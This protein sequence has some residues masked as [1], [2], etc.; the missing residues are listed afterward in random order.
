MTKNSSLSNEPKETDENFKEFRQIM[1]ELSPASLFL[2]WKT[3]WQMKR[4]HPAYQHQRQELD[5]R[6]QEIL[7]VEE[8]FLS[9]QAV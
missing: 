7:E 9:L 5:A 3:L 4:E 2:I 1:R 8:K 6:Y